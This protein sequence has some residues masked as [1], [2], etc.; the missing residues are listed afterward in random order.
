MTVVDTNTIA[1]LFL[2]TKFTDSVEQLLILD[3]HWVAPALWRSELRNILA[4]QIRHEIIDFETATDIQSK[5]EDILGNNEYAV[6]SISVL[7]LAK[8]SGCTACDCEF[9]ALAQSLKAKLIT[10]DKKLVHN[11]PS[12][13]MKAADY[14]AAQI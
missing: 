9:I 4:T 3:S 13:A 2:P 7:S 1:Y 5:A 12:I 8:E 14:I 10:A 6:D 11:F